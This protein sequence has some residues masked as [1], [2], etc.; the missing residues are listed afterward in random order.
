MQVL[1]SANDRQYIQPFQLCDVV[2]I[3]G[4]VVVGVGIEPLAISG[5]TQEGV[6]PDSEGHEGFW[7]LRSLSPGTSRT[8]QGKL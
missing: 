5:S 1:E 2:G 8:R 3:C 7:C 6:C 4:V